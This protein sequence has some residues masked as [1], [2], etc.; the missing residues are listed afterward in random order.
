MVLRCLTSF[1]YKI[2]KDYMNEAGIDFPS[3]PMEDEENYS[4][5]PRKRIS[6]YSSSIHFV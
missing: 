4:S 3:H 5:L 2:M 1:L 6:P